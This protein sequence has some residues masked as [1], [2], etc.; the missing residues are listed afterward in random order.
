MKVKNYSANL[1]R[2]SIVAYDIISTVPKNTLVFL[3]IL[4]KNQCVLSDL[5]K[6][7][8]S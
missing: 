6:I 3:A 7:I 5:S 2:A 8:K 4:F 1:W